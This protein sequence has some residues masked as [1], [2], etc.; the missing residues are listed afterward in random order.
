MPEPVKFYVSLKVI[1]KNKKGE[2]LGLKCPKHSTMSGFYDLPGGRIDSDELNI[3]FSKIIQ[4]EMKEEVGDKVKFS[5]NEK[6]VAI[7]RHIAYSPRAKKIVK[8]FMVFFEGQYLSGEIKISSEHTGFKWLKLNPR[9][10]SKFFT[11]GVL[12]G[13]RNYL[14]HNRR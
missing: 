2:I 7:S 5:L 12:E 14:K 3:P 10:L 9:S 8:I 6:P 4:R 11:K 13:L 1:L